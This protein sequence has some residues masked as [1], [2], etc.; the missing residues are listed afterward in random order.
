M[1]KN[2]NLTR[3]CDLWKNL[4]LN[5]LIFLNRKPITNSVAI[6]HVGFVELD[7]I[8]QYSHQITKRTIGCGSHDVEPGHVMWM[9]T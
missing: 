1:V 9:Q 5:I 8:Y 6:N 4:W 3:K 7:I 2:S